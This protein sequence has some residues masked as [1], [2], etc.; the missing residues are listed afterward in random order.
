MRIFSVLMV[1]SF[2]LIAGIETGDL[3]A[4]WVKDGVSVT[5]NQYPRFHRMIPDGAGGAIVVWTDSP[6]YHLDVQRIDIDGYVQWTVDGV[7]VCT[8]SSAQHK[9]ALML[10]GLGSAIITWTDNRV[11]A[12]GIYAQKVTELHGLKPVAS[13]LV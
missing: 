13:D 7:A 8:A 5:S 2:L 10:D 1:L 9:P 6:S 3:H 11:G 4:Q 12:R